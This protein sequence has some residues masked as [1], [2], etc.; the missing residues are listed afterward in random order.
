[1]RVSVCNFCS[2]ALEMLKFST[3]SIFNNAG[4][5]DFD[6]LITLWRPSDEVEEYVERLMNARGRRIHRIYHKED[7]SIGYVP[8]LRVMMNTGLN[9]GFALNPWATIVNTDMYFGPFWLTGLIKYMGD[10]DVAVS[11]LHI[12]PIKGNKPGIFTADFGVP[13]A[14]KFDTDEFYL[15]YE[16][17]RGKGYLAPNSLSIKWHGYQTMPTIFHRSQWADYGPWETDDIPGQP[18]PDR[19]FFGRMFYGGI[20]YR[21]SRESVVY[22]HEA[23]ERR[24]EG[25]PPGTEIKK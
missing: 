7:N 21:L 13:E 25:P 24:R 15:M 19:R 18:P 9:A 17:I 6:Y 14:G 8:N 20:Q 12:T 2:T 5:T 1:M 23:V 16:A 11:S 3:E 10:K 22:H 4:T